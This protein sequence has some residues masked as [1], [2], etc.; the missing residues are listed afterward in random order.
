MLRCSGQRDSWSLKVVDI[1]GKFS[2]TGGR[3]IR[4]RSQS[5]VGG[6]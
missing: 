6:G 5:G 2:S 4:C 3:V 1:S